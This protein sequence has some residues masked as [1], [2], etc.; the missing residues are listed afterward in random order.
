MLAQLHDAEVQQDGIL[1]QPHGEGVFLHD[2]GHS[3]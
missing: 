2:E 3:T 1:V